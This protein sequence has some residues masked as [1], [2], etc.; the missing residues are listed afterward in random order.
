MMTRPA[1]I[2]ELRLVGL[3]HWPNTEAPAPSADEHRGEAQHEKQRG[4]HARAATVSVDA[5]PR[6][7]ICSMVV[8]PR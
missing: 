3:I 2:D 1:T 7:V 8:P 4:Q 6:S 5:A